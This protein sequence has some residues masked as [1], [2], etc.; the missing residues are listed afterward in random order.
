MN[1]PIVGKE[2]TL[3]IIMRMMPDEDLLIVVEKEY[4][5][6]EVDGI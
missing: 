6:V 2:Y 3:Q 1:V 5:L 4:D